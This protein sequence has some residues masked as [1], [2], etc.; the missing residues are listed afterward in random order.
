M[1]ETRQDDTE[2]SKQRRQQATPGRFERRQIKQERLQPTEHDRN[3]QVYI[4]MNTHMNE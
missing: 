4:H 2:A 3:T 1:P